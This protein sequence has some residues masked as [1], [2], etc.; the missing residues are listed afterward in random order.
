MEIEMGLRNALRE[1]CQAN[2]IK[3]L[4]SSASIDPVEPRYLTIGCAPRL[5]LVCIWTDWNVSEKGELLI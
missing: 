3:I 4:S 5:C 2:P 1:Q